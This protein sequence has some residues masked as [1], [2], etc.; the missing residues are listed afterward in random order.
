MA[1][2][3]IHTKNLKWVDITNPDESD[4]LY[5]KDNFRFHPLDFE[6]VVTPAAR[7]KVDEYDDYHFVILLFPLL[8]RKTDE[9]RAAEVDFF[10]GKGYL[11]TI[12]DG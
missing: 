5:L 9:I 2:K 3:I 11:V 8:D 1:I 10:I 4:L 7:A 6:D 12:H